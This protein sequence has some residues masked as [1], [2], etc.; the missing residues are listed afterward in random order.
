MTVSN[1]VNGRYALMSA[2]TRE[3]VERVIAALNYRRHT[4][5]HSLRLARRFSI[6]MVIVDPD[7]FFLADPFIT[8]VV[9]G[10][11]N[12]LGENGYSLVLVGCPAERLD[13]TVVVRNNGTDA[14]C[15]MLSG[16]HRIRRRCFNVVARLAQ[17]TILFQ[18]A[19]PGSSH[20][21]CAIQQ[22][23]RGGAALLTRHV[24]EQGARQL[25]MLVPSLA[26]PA[27]EEREQGIRSVVSEF[28]DARIDILPCGNCSY[29]DTQAAIARRIE[30]RG[31]PDAILAG[32]DQMGIATLKWLR[33]RGTRVPDDVRITGFNA[34]DFWQYSDPVLTTVRSPAYEMGELGG[35]KLLDRL[36]S[37]KFAEREI[38]L[39]VTMVL[40]ASA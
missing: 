22:D 29:H 33:A 24:M 23:D 3:R 26:W 31:L 8:N 27:I 1:V 11:S 34:F 19:I 38:V 7:P 14:C 15:I 6:A 35:R 36:T 39:P 40:G 21:V 28:S 12:L 37:G 4:S 9:A 2:E 30:A 32:N 10:L 17:P 5:G 13:E 18:E 25:L 16:P 20:D